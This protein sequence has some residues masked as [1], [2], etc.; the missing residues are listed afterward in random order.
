MF[1]VLCARQML[2]SPIAQTAGLP[3]PLTIHQV[4]SLDATYTDQQHGITFRYPSVWKPATGF[5]YVPPALTFASGPYEKQILMRVTGFGYLPGEYP[6]RV[7]GP[8]TTTNL[9]GFGLVY[10][11]LEVASAAECDKKAAYVAKNAGNTRLPSVKI[12]GRSYAVYRIA[13]EAMN[14]TYAG[15]LYATYSRGACYLIETGVAAVLPRATINGQLPTPASV[16][17]VEGQLWRLMKTVRI[18]AKR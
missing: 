2:P 5:G 9:E 13:G 12:A 18:F 11:V 17:D 7:A 14:Q 1:V 3:K 4:W 10:S 8:Y 16:Y 6:R 15:K